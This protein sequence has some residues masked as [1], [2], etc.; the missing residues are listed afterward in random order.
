MKL[1]YDIVKK[2]R[3]Q[4]IRQIKQTIKNSSFEYEKMGKLFELVM[5]H[6]EKEEAFYAQKLYGTQPNNT[7]R[8]TKSRLK[9]MLEN[10]LLND[11]S[12]SGYD[13]ESINIQ[14]QCRKKLLQGK[15]L[16]GRGAYLGS[17][18]LLLQVIASAQK[19]DLYTELFEAE[20]L[21]YRYY[22]IRD[23]VKE[24][25][26]RTDKL[27]AENQQQALINEALI[28]YHS[29]SNLLLHQTLEPQKQEEVRSTVSR[30][31]HI[32]EETQHPTTRHVHYLSQIYFLQEVRQFEEALVYCQKYLDLLQSG[33]NKTS[34]QRVASAYVQLAIVS[35]QLGNL[36]D[37]QNYLEEVFKRYN[38]EEMNY[39]AALEL[40]F[41]IA[42]KS[43]QYEVAQKQIEIS[44]EHPQFQASKLLAAKW[45]YFHACLLFSQAN[46]QEA[47]LKLNDTSPLLAD[48]QGMNLYIR[49]L[50]IMI[51]YELG[52]YDLME[53]KI[54]NMRQFVKRTRK[55][56]RNSRPSLLIQLL[57]SWYK[58]QYNFAE[59]YAQAQAEIDSLSQLHSADAF[60]NSGFELIKFEEWILK[61]K[62]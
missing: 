11:K 41:L 50:E 57:M 37:A 42:F 58:N 30:I 34:S 51:M 22:G 4:E 21:L 13:S 62:G 61:K 39:L 59:I 29:V 52:H 12:L 7:F 35:L 60:R 5:R 23:S 40:A 9:R 55:E 31:Q 38:P 49:L 47:Y 24:F 27:L 45:H 48:K 16:L 14:L 53:T 8:V 43:Q 1:I 19:Y 28:L 25:E 56:E 36:T 6:E 33:K 15:I 17:K 44:F 54:L 2:L 20:L 18:N 26:K 3:K 46:Y 10:V 32:Y